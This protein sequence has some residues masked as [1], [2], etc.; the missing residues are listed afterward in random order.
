MKGILIILWSGYL[1]CTLHSCILPPSVCL[2][3]C[4]SPSYMLPGGYGTARGFFFFIDTR[5]NTRPREPKTEAIYNADLSVNSAGCQL[6]NTQLTATA[7]LTC[8]QQ[9]NILLRIHFSSLHATYWD[10]H[11]VHSLWVKRQLICHGGGFW[12]RLRSNVRIYQE[13]FIQ[14]Q[15]VTWRKEWLIKHFISFISTLRTADFEFTLKRMTVQWCTV[16]GLV[17]PVIIAVCSE[18]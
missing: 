11:S 17:C 4:L 6:I 5:V 7:S 12:C 10:I 16:I 9:K 2:S 3:L 1:M 18:S 8:L 13:F 15:L 14:S